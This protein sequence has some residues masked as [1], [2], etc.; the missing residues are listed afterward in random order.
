M[1]ICINGG[2]TITDFINMEYNYSYLLASGTKH[3]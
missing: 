1:H 2:L 3:K